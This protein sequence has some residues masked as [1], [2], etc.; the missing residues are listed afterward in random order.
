[1]RG[2]GHLLRLGWRR[3]RWMVLATLALL[4]VLTWA[5]AR[6]TID[7][8]ADDAARVAAARMANG[9]S[10]V[11]AT[12]GTVYDVHSIAGLGG[13]KVQMIDFV[14][15]AFLVIALVRRHT[16]S[17][18]ETGRYE[19]LGAGIVAPP[20]PLAA[21][22]LFATVVSLV[23]G[24][25]VALGAGAGGFPWAG[26]WA[27]GAAVA[28]VGLA[29]T[30][31]A[32]IA[33][34]LSPSTRACSGFVYTALGA[35]YVLRMIG[36]LREGAAG[37]FARWLSP[38]GW[39]QQVRAWNGDRWWVLV[40]FPVFAVVGYVVA[41]R[42][43][44]VRDLGGGLFADRHGR[45]EGRIGSVF[46]LGWRLQRASLVGW[47]TVAV[48][49]GLVAGALIGSLGAFLNGA[50]E[51]MLRQLGGVG[52]ADELF[53]SL[54][55][56]IAALIA[57]AYGVAAVLRA[58]EEEASGHAEALLSTRET[59]GRLLGTH[60]LYGFGGS[61]VFLLAMGIAEVL[62]WSPA[63]G[64]DL[65]ALK[66]FETT[67]VQIPS[68]WVVV[69]LAVAV[70]GLWP[71]ISWLGWALL[72]GF[73]ALGELGDL[74]KLPTWLRDLSP[75]AHTPKMPAEPFAAGPVV[76]MLLIAAAG[77]VLGMLAFR[78]RDLAA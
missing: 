30:V 77:A 46:G 4:W 13:T 64:S 32:A 17:D 55:A 45:S 50:A 19:L 8:Y 26:S 47:V 12:Y 3:D 53:V 29:F 23:G 74:L 61:A 49:L 16:R 76:V 28:G 7:L 2:T 58:R 59:R 63:P 54:Y 33:M 69:A 43:R 75:Y 73:I 35:S 31:L 34:Q 44:V 21:A 10:S 39:G 78:R 66:S 41:D 25:G 22:V 36:D 70:F 37:G 51:N 9:L 67:L 72:I 15:I 5:S 68:V 27:V 48:A 40:V 14:I 24:A 18:E 1:M 60:L 11:V 38:L 52:I 65:T 42:L 6:A 62:V 57:S 56:G 71:R 20:A